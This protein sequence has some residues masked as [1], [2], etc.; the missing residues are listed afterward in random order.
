MYYQER[1]FKYDK[2]WHRNYRK[3][4]TSENGR[5]FFKTPKEFK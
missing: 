5:Y 2:E 3:E 1:K 4:H